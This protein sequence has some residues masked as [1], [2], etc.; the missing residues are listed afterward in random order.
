MAKVYNLAD[1][2]A[3]GVGSWQF[4][5]FQTM[6]LTIWLIIN[7]LKLVDYDPFPFILLNLLLSFQAAYTGPI[8][9]ISANRQAEIDRKRAMKN[10]NIDMQ[11]HQ[12]IIR[13]EKHIDEH[14]H[15]LLAKLG[16]PSESEKV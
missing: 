8:L 9:L 15:Q 11:D 4:I 5:V 2:I 16:V 13:L 3:S 10:L 7:A 12:I 6:F 1:R 14:F